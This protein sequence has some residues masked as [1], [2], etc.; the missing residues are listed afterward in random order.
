MRDLHTRLCLSPLCGLSSLSHSASCH[1]SAPVQYIYARIHTQKHTLSLIHTHTYRHTHTQIPGQL[2]RQVAR[3]AKPLQQLSSL[4]SCLHD[5]SRHDA[6]T[7][8]DFLV[9]TCGITMWFQTLIDKVLNCSSLIHRW[10][11]SAALVTVRPRLKMRA[12]SDLK[13]PLTET[14]V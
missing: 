12:F 4:G 5:N 7:M 3:T 14:S 6:P 11:I 8:S 1:Y 9:F 13:N 10:V 2:L